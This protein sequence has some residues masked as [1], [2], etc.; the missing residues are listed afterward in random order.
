MGGDDSTPHCPEDGDIKIE[1]GDDVQAVT[2]GKLTGEV[3]LSVTAW[4]MM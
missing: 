2:H 3:L 4:S 1:K